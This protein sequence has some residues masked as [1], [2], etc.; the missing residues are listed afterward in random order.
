M[1]NVFFSAKSKSKD[2][3]DDIIVL[4]LF[5]CIVGSG[6]L[7]LWSLVSGLWCRFYAISLLSFL[8]EKFPSTIDTSTALF[9]RWN[10][11]A[12]QWDETL[13]ICLF[14]C[15]IVS[16]STLAFVYSIKMTGLD[17]IF[18]ICDL[19]FTICYWD[20]GSF[21]QPRQAATDRERS[22]SY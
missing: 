5:R 15:P 3:M 10:L 12:Q 21:N 9:R 14:V 11:F 20:F 19:R 18:G 1:R 16:P 13:S 6:F 2:W 22:D 4:T 17:W 8:G 7:G